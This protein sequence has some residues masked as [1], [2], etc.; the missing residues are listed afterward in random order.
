MAVLLALAVGVGYSVAGEPVGLADRP[1]DYETFGAVGDGVA[2]DLPAI[3]KAHAFANAHGLT[4]KTKPGATYHLGRRALTAIIAT[5]TDWGT[6]K[7]IIDDTD[8]E[9]HRLSL[10]VV[11]SRLEPETLV[12]PRLVRDQPRLDVRPQR[13]CWVRVENSHWRRY[14]REGL[15][16]N[17]GS[18]QRDCFIL[19]RDGTIEGAIDWDYDVVTRVEARPIDEQPLVLRG[20][21]FTTRANRM[22]QEQGYNYWLRNIAITRSN[23][24]VVGLTHHVVDEGEFGHPYN[25][26][27]A[28]QGCAN[29]V[30]RDC[31]VTGHK[32]YSTIGSAG[33]PVSMGSYD[34]NANEVVNFTMTGVRMDNICD[35][36]RWGVIGT[37]FC[38][39][40]VL[41][42]CTLS[43]MDSH[44]G[45][46]GLYTIRGTTLGHAGLN[47]IGRG[48]LTI[49]DSTLN[50]RALLSLRADYGSTWEGTVV[51]RNSRWRPG[52]GAP[53]QP[54]LFAMAN[55]GQHDFGYPCFM[56]A[57]IVIDG[58][59]IEDSQ[60]PSDYSGP[61]LFNDP[62][63]KTPPGAARP[64]PYQLTEQ[65]TIRRL[66]TA[67]GQNIRISPD[68][69]FAARVKMIQ[70][71]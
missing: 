52:C 54:T 65:V 67:S 25:G 64:F 31:F 38:K 34:L 55:S 60:H 45:V 17:N 71:E 8:V 43:R 10:F 59:V 69:E 7:F 1:V 40:I 23:T 3:V 44:Q 39:N 53:I 50:G 56:P 15:N 19:R 66:T 20:G 11:Q 21:I 68:A 12:I 37:N 32:T 30:F 51:I 63:G 48:T 2:D 70:Q 46:S 41:E 16:Q 49:E 28:A 35:A 42:N 13:D 14:I 24:T 58:L 6:S 4:V 26:F 9:N 33:K 36:T 18:A 62:D 27:L 29:I 57:Q 22:K 47:A 5:D 61:F